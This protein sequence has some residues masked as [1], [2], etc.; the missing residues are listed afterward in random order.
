[1]ENQDDILKKFIQDTENEKSGNN[2][3]KETSINNNVYQ[4]EQTNPTNV[5]TSALDYLNINIEDLPMGDFY[6]GGFKVAIRAA[7][8]AEIQAYSIVNE[9]NIY[10]VTEKMNDML[11]ACVRV[12]LPNGKIGSYLDIKDGDRIYLIFA[13]RELTFQKGSQLYLSASCNACKEKNNI[14]MVREHFHKSLIP[15]EIKPYFD[16]ESRKFIFELIN[17]QVISLAP[18]SIGLQK[19]FYD[20]L[21]KQVDDKEETNIAFIKVIPWTMSERNNITHEGAEKKLLEF[22]TMNKDTFLF[23][24]AAINKMKFGIEKMAKPCSAC[25]TEVH[26]DFRFPIGAA[27]LFSVHDPFGKYLK[28]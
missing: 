7:K 23:L 11:K 20:F 26:T 14:E 24:D 22:Q 18:P 12:T 3:F 16:Y 9:K 10:D 5:K 27:G 6:S 28:K 4:Q 25:G 15:E 8:V 19:S 2:T 17:G 13:I 1:M 21:K